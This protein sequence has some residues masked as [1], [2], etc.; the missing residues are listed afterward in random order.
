MAQPESF[1]DIH[2]HLLPGVDDGARDWDECLQMARLAVAEGIGTAIA[3]PHQC[4]SYGRNDGDTIRRHVA[5]VQAFL[6]QHQVPL[7]VLPGGDVRIEPGLAARLRRGDVLSLADRHRH[8]LLELPHEIYF[9]LEPLLAELSAAGIVGVLS[10]P[11]RN[12]GIAGDPRVMG[13]LVDGG[14]LMQITAGSLLGEF[15]SQAQQLSEQWIRQGLVHFIATDAHDTKIRRAR[16]RE[17]FARVVELAG[18]EAARDLCSRWPAAVAEGRDVPAGR[19]ET[20]RGGSWFGWRR[21]G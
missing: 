9:P 6:D 14:C 10:H 13:P 8:V 17:V 18:D 21:A 5:A 15:G 12:A 2:C 4:G 20:A 1:V 19:R 16:M 3:T 11:E 7:R